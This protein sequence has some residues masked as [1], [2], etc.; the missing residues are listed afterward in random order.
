MAARKRVCITV[1]EE[2]LRPADREARRLKISRN[3][4]IRI[5]ASIEVKKAGS[6][7]KER[8]QPKPG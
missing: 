8:C 7:E 1:D 5:A 2:T 3:D 6:Q 4:F